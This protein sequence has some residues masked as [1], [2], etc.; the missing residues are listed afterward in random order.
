MLEKP[1]TSRRISTGCEERD[2]AVAIVILP[3]L[4]RPASEES[5]V[6]MPKRPP[7]CIAE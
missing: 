4:T 5:M 2:S 1:C 6:C 3:A 7:A